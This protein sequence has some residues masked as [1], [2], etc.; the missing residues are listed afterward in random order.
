MGK[1]SRFNFETGQ[2]AGGLMERERSWSVLGSFGSKLRR[3]E[4]W[5]ESLPKERSY[6]RERQIRRSGVVAY[7]FEEEWT[8][9]LGYG[10]FKMAMGNI[11][12]SETAI[13]GAGNSKQ[14]PGNSLDSY[15]VSSSAGQQVWKYINLLGS[16]LTE[17]WEGWAAARHFRMPWTIINGSL[18]S[19]GSKSL[20]LESRASKREHF[21]IEIS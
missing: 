21:Q 7:A 14:Q 12:D 11:L 2:V 4:N 10:A 17:S 6:P 9:T 15:K 20:L 19:P 1:R 16:S 8:A 3:H 5:R 18:G 13:G